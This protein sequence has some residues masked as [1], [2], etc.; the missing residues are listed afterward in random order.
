MCGV[1]CFGWFWSNCLPNGFPLNGGLPN[2]SHDDIIEILD[3]KKPKV[4]S[5]IN[6]L[7]QLKFEKSRFDVF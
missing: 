6:C 2:C 4:F 7:K 3:D 1:T 5:S